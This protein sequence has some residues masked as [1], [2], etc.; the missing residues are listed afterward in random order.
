M[1]QQLLLL[2]P[3]LVL[4]LLL[5]GLSDIHQFTLSCGIPFEVKL[6]RGLTERVLRKD[7][8]FIAKEVGR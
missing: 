1:R 4:L 3:M 5:I 6:E 7:E 8:R 2:Q